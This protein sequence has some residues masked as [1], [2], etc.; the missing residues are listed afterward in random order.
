MRNIKI[1]INTNNKLIGCKCLKENF[2]R[3]YAIAPYHFRY[4]KLYNV[5]L[6]LGFRVL[7]LF[8]FPIDR[9][10]IFLM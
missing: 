10:D 2:L 6:P 1:T 3:K 7:K 4:D 5:K 8:S 9:I